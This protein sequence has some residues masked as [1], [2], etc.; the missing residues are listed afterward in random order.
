[1]SHDYNDASEPDRLYG[2]DIISPRLIRKVARFNRELE[3][4]QK[5]GEQRAREEEAI[6]LRKYGPVS[7]QVANESER[8]RKLAEQKAY[9][10]ELKKRDSEN[11]ILKSDWNVEP[12][13][14]PLIPNP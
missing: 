11:P 4:E 1:M 2:I 10:L 12:P 8:L 6:H 9:I 3:L 13:M 7:V 14:G 5:R